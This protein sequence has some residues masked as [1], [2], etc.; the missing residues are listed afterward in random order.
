MV[1]T[2]T[3]RLNMIESQVRPSDVVDRR[4]PIAMRAIPRERFVPPEIQAIAYMDTD[5]QIGSGSESPRVLLAPRVLAKMIQHLELE[6]T[7]IVLV[8]GCTTGYSTAVL[9]QIAQTVVGLEQDIDL[10]KASTSNLE[11]VEADNT[12]IVQGDLTEGH[13][14]EGPY[15][16]ILLNG[17]IADELPMAILDQLK[18]GGRLVAIVGDQMHGRCM[19]WRRIGETFDSRWLFDAAAPVLPGFSANPQFEF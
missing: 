14:S 1:D 4:I 19:Q 8:I 11:R 18:D 10:V 16:A 3:Q 17:A 13:A 5:L 15:D 7:D 12:A 9:S 2:A 6:S